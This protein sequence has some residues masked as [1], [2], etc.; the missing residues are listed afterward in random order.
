M[1]E[2]LFL[3]KYAGPMVRVETNMSQL[4]V[5]IV[6]DDDITR[7]Q[8]YSEECSDIQGEVFAASKKKELI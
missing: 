1:K 7:I 8:K 5:L 6:S 4:T 3:N 2:L